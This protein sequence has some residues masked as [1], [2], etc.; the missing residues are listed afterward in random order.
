MA[1]P[2]VVVMA[3]NGI[4]RTRTERKLYMEASK[5]CAATL[6]I[7]LGGLLSST[8]AAADNRVSRSNGVTTLTLTNPGMP[9]IGK[10]TAMPLPAATNGP[11]VSLSPTPIAWPGAPGVS[12][13]NAGTGVETPVFVGLSPADGAEVAPQEYGV[14]GPYTFAI[15]Y[16]TARADAKGTTTSKFYPFRAAGK[17]Y[18]TDPQ[19]GYNYVCS[20]SLIKPGVVVTAA[21][22]VAS[23]GENRFYTNWRFIPAYKSG[24]APYG[25]WAVAQ[26]SV[27]TSYLDGTDTCSAAGVVCQNDVAV[28]V[29]QPQ[30]DA[31]GAS[32][33]AGKNTGWLA[34]GVNGFGF[35][36]NNTQVTQ[37]GYPVALDSGAIMER[38][39]SMGLVDTSSVNNTIIGSLQT[40]G[41]SGGPWVANLGVKPVLSGI[42]FGTDS[43]ANTVV[44]VT[45]WGF[46]YSGYKIQGAS[47][48]TS[49][50]ISVLVDLSCSSVPAA[51]AKP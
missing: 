7:C 30:T 51:C 49:S 31:A 14:P 13:G 25:T 21:H 4:T 48:F 1:P 33:Y 5:I 50:N 42:T 2:V 11:V 34:Y 23:F 41:S 18:F 19:S 22:C 27:V 44:G 17:L 10:A 16:T 15:P 26:A 36:G 9:D 45:S 35:T 3:G 20:A 6:A 40:G 39:D 32:Y 8:T 37:L 12:T 47:P 24:T 43:R 29:L 28:L 46:T 38:T